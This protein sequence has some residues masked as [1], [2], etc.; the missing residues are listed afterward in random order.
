VQERPLIDPGIAAG[1]AE[2]LSI[3]F[4]E[5][6]R[7]IDRDILAVVIGP[8]D[9]AGRQAVVV[10]SRIL[11]RHIY[12]EEELIFPA[13]RDAG[14]VGPVLVM[15][16]EH[17]E[18]WPLL[19][20]VERLAADG[21][22]TALQDACATLLDLLARHNPK[23]EVILYPRVDDAL[24]AATATTLRRLLVDGELPTGWRCQLLR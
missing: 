15:L 12:A 3:G 13:L 8:A 10:A 2:A 24:D 18:M 1:G 20:T 16:R 23:E 19:D 21:E 22:A 4:E 11:R 7:A 6:H 9:L 5:E 17:A 14:L